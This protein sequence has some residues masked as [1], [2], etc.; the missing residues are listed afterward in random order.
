MEKE[1][2]LKISAW[3]WFYSDSFDREE[4]RD[5]SEAM[6]RDGTTAASASVD[7]NAWN[8]SPAAVGDSMTIAIAIG[9]GWPMVVYEGVAEG[10]VAWSMVRTGVGCWR[11][12]WM[13]T[14]S[15]ENKR[16]RWKSKEKSSAD[17]LFFR[18]AAEELVIL[19]HRILLVLLVLFLVLFLRI[20]LNTS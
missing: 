1:A 2:E 7:A 18:G 5:N 20:L 6:E 16:M 17:H 10:G 3:N 14:T 13:Q 19:F 8:K 15:S 9:H 12:E 11:W 4:E